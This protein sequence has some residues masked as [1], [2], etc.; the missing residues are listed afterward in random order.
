[1]GNIELCWVDHAY[2]FFFGLVIPLMVSFQGK[3]KLGK[4]QW[5]SEEKIRA[6]I[7]NGLIMWAAAVLVLAIWFGT[8]RSFQDFGFKAPSINIFGMTAIAVLVLAYFGDLIHEIFTDSRRQSLIEKWSKNAPFLP[9]NSREYRY[10]TFAGFSAGFCEEIIYRGFMINYLLACS[11]GHWSAWYMAMLLPAIIFGALHSYQGHIAVN[12]I[13]FGG[14]LFGLIYY[15]TQ[16]FL[17]VVIIHFAI[18]MISAYVHQ[19]LWNGRAS[20]NTKT[21]E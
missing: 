21:Q 9:S 1:M 15:Y 6:Y 8:G 5:T 16:S 20:R 12:K 13:I 17:L 2:M 14:I 4:S 18:D 10:F 11:S 19:R 3:P 7:A